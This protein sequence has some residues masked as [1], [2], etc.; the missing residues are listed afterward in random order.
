M[1]FSRQKYERCIGSDVLI[2]DVGVLIESVAW[3]TWTDSVCRDSWLDIVL[4]S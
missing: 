2:C 3:L 4:S 1:V